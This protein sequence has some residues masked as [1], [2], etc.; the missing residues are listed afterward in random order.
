MTYV[1]ARASLK[2][3][4]S[5]YGRGKGACALDDVSLSAALHLASVLSLSLSLSLSMYVYV[6]ICTHLY[7]YVYKGAG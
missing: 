3:L 2:A 6:Y 1:E 7:V 4:L 5:K